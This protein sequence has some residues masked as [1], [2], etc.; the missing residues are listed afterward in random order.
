MIRV[1]CDRCS[2]R[3]GQWHKERGQTS[4][5]SGPRMMFFIIGGIS[6]SEMRCAY[7]VTQ[8]SKNW[9]ILVGTSASRSI[10]F[11]FSLLCTL[12][13]IT[14]FF[15]AGLASFWCKLLVQTILAEFLANVYMLS[16]VCLS[17]VCNARVPYSGGSNFRNISTALGTLAIRWHPLKILRRS[18]QGNP[19]ARG[20][21]HNRGSKIQRFRTYRRLYLGNGAR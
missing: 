12:Q 17:S 7:E 2:A 16:P 18:S 6:Y 15:K 11:S 4:A 19:F 13:C 5:K 21:K 8:S 10:D 9:E 3:Y 20:V 14:E 1:D